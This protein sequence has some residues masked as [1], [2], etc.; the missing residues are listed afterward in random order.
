MED[1]VGS[2]VMLLAHQAEVVARVLGD[3]KC[4][5][6]LADEVGLGKT[7]EACVILKGLQHR[8]PDI[9]ALIIAPDSLVTQWKN[10]L[11]QKFWLK[12]PIVTVKSKIP[13]DI[14]NPGCIISIEDLADHD[15]LSSVLC[16]G[17]N[18]IC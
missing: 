3:P 6:V 17:R 5:Y 18:G 1:L 2:R 14:P 15:H 12:F 4:R 11:D 9:K 8:N 13:E 10:E 16:L 7:I